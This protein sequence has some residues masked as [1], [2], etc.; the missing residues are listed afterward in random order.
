[1][2]NT[3]PSSQTSS[4]PA[5]QHKRFTGVVVSARMKDTAVVEVSRYIKHPKYGKYLTRSK[6]FKAHD[7]GNKHA[8]G[9]KVTIEECR[10]ISKDKHF[11]IV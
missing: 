6:R 11:R 10:P 2:K 9:E 7:A 5:I 1:M 8:V 3:A 4:A